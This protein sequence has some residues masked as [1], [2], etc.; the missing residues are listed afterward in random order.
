VSSTAPRVLVAAG[1]DPTGGAGL[2]AD[3]EALLAVGARAMAVATALTLQG[4]CGAAGWEAVSP[5][6]VARQ[7]EELVRG[8]GERPRALKTG[9]LAGGATAAALAR[10]FSRPPLARLPLV[11]DP[12]LAASTGLSLF[13]HGHRHTPLS[14]LLPLVER[15]TVV[16]PNRPELEA[17]TGAPL[18]DDAAAIEAARRLPC[19]AVLVKGGHRAGAPVDLLVR[20]RTV[21]RF[22][23]RRREGTA[24]G[25]GCRLASAIAAGLAQGKPLRESV[26]VARDVVRRHLEAYPA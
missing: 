19:R 17:L 5:R 13:G 14:A 22:E 7:V 24:R 8:R 4:P 26:L 16:T 9:M 21:K 15:A 2:V 1:L 12:V 20:G 3:V 18:E 10:I 11:V 6:F 25:T 23:G